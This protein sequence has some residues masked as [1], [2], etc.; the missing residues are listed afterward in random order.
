[1]AFKKS[2]SA[3]PPCRVVPGLRRS[4]D[5]TMLHDVEPIG[6]TQ[7]PDG[8][9]ML[10]CYRVRGR[11]QT[12][13]LRYSQEDRWCAADDDDSRRVFPSKC[14]LP[15]TTSAIL[16]RFPVDDHTCCKVTTWS[17]C[18]KTTLVCIRGRVIIGAE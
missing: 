2:A 14:G 17:Y 8:M 11:V 7:M 5:G 12:C 3:T 18:W 15:R 13:S 1:M 16:T 10:S 6:W 4:C 9:T